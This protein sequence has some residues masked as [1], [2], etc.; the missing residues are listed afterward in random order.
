MSSHFSN[1]S[2]Q[3]SYNACRQ[4]PLYCSP[5]AIMAVQTNPGQTSTCLDIHVIS[6]SKPYFHLP[7]GL[8]NVHLW[9][10][11]IRIVF[12]FFFFVGSKKCPYFGGFIVEVRNEHKSFN[13]F[14][15]LRNL[16]Q[17][18]MTWRPLRRPWGTCYLMGRWWSSML[19]LL[20]QV[21]HW[22]YFVTQWPENLKVP[23]IL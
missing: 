22:C 7:W 8:Y 20:R 6:Y 9:K 2:G 15:S 13:I 5:L 21:V 16:I 18:S 23:A 12:F 1:L 4:C 17:T 11:K 10:S 3:F 19:R 14:C